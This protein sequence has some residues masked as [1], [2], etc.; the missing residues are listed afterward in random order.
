[1]LDEVKNVDV[2]KLPNKLFIG[3]QWVD[4]EAGNTIDVLN[5]HDNSKITTI[6]E[7]READIDKAV[8][9]AR[10]DLTSPLP[11][12]TV[13]RARRRGRDYHGRPGTSRA[14]RRGERGRL[15]GDR[16]ELPI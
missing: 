13:A 14:A 9:A 11:G 7:A 3:G 5:P 15:G 6:P 12:F 1:M 2:D 16:A 4:A 8:A 10:A